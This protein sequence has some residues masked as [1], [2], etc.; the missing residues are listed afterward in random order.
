MKPIRHFLMMEQ[1]SMKYTETNSEKKTT[2][3]KSKKNAVIPGY[4]L[5]LGIVITM[6]SVIV[7][8][9]LASVLVLFS[10]DFTGGVSRTDFK[11]KCQERLFY[12]YHKLFSR[13]GHQCGVWSYR[14][15]ESG[16]I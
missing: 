8:I 6:L 16:Q 13:G 2:K 14:G 12:Q 11:R 4:H 3:T 9:P 7:L 10:S 1:C 15:M 5:S